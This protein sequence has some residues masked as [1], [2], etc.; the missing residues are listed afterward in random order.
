M[1]VNIMAFITGII[2]LFHMLLLS[3]LLKKIIG[4]HSRYFIGS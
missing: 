1:Y 4:K 3:I 2:F